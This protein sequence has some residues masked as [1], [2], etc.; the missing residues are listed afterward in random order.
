MTSLTQVSDMVY[1]GTKLPKPSGQDFI[2]PIIIGQAI[3]EIN[4]VF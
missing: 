4:F 1:G 2:I 3:F